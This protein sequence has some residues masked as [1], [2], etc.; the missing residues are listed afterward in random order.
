MEA[1]VSRELPEAFP[2][3]RWEFNVILLEI[4]VLG[5]AGIGALVA[6]GLRLLPMVADWVWWTIAIFLFGVSYLPLESILLRTQHHRELSM[7]RS[8]TWIV[9]GTA[10]GALIYRLMR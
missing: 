6:L 10:I 7:V 5:G 2:I 4:V 3:Q 8:I 1:H 9:A